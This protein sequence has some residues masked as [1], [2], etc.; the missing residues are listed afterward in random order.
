MTGAVGLVVVEAGWATS[1]Q[2]GG[3]PG[4]ADIGVSRSGAL[5]QPLRA[6]LNLLVGNRKDAA[7]LETLGG[8]RLQPTAAVVIA[9]SAERIA[10]A[11]V[12]GETIDV[13]PAAGELWGYLAVRGGIAVEPVLGSRSQDSRSGLGPDPVGAAG[14]VPVG[15]PM[16]DPVATEQAPPPPPTSE[17]RIWPGPRIDWF[18]DDTI[19][20]LTNAEWTVSSEVSRVGVRLDGPTLRPHDRGELPS[21]GLLLGA[22]QVPPDGRPIVMLADHPTT[23]GY[24][25]VAVVD[26][27]SVATVAQARP[28]SR[29]RLRLVQ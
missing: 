5:D 28:G 23:G 25:V 18:D 8:L 4:Y 29:L 15:A 10:R 19:T 27:E 21:E 1:I 9:V 14:H 6:V 26:P 22:I 20:S 3:R 11:V 16:S 24:P 13:E 17:V 12:A 7:V 2:D